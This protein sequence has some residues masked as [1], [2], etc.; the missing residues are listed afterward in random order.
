[1]SRRILLA[2][3]AVPLLALACHGVS[4]DEV[5]RATSPIG[6][7]DAVLVETNGGATTSF[8]YE[9]YLVSRAGAIDS[10]QRVGHL[11]GAVRNEQAYGVNLRWRS[12]ERLELE[13]YSAISATLQQPSLRVGDQLVHVALASGVKDPEAPPGGMLF[14]LQ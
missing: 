5:A 1:M 4:R 6:T 14:N 9:V 2:S 8:G 7:V 10:A 12:A 3:L 13:Y 11:Y